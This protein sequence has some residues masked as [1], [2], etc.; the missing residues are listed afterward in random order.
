MYKLLYIY[1]K[2]LL[3]YLSSINS[4]LKLRDAQKSII[5]RNLKL[6]NFYSFY[7]IKPLTFKNWKINANLIKYF[8][9]SG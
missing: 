6:F 9:M 3:S 5:Y 4:R 8:L 1:M 7:F 2:K